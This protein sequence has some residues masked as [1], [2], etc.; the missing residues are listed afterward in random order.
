MVGSE[1]G[2]FAFYPEFHPN[3]I[4]VVV[5]SVPAQIQQLSYLLCGLAMLYEVP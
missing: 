2:F 3:I 5:D 1:V 4:S